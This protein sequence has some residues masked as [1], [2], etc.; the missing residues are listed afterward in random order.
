MTRAFLIVL[1]SFGIGG[2]PDAAAF[3]DAGADTLGHI[4]IACAEGRGNRDGLRAGPLRLPNLSAMGL[5]HAAETAS[6]AWPM[7]LERPASPRAL[8]GHAVEQSTGK[9]T[10]SG[11]WEIA[12][13]PVT[14]AWGYFPNSVPCFPSALTDALIAKGGLPGLLGNGHAS[15]TEII[16]ALGTE[17][18]ATGK[19]ILYTS[20]DSV[21]QIAAHE[22][23][24]GLERIRN[25][26]GFGGRCRWGN[27][28]GA[29][30]HHW[31]KTATL[32]F[33]ICRPHLSLMQQPAR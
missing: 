22:E 3:G 32:T 13:V 4:A 15:G 11:H 33:P 27:R 8:Y 29:I 31:M 14:R 26:A 10:P 18:L 25:R 5:G 16:A 21:L 9:D 19:P 7:G 17:H 2:A 23:A 30:S 24:F 20:A 28:A 6:G 1:D 12:G